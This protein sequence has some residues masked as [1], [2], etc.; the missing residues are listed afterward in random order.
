MSKDNSQPVRTVANTDPD[1]TEASELHKKLLEVNKKKNV[2]KQVKENPGKQPEFLN[3]IRNETNLLQPKVLLEAATMDKKLENATAGAFGTAMLEVVFGDDDRQIV[4]N[5]M[6]S[7]WRKITALRILASDGRSFAGTGWFISPTVLITA[8]HCVYMPK[9]GGWAQKIEVI[10]ALN[11]SKKPFGSTTATRFDTNEEWIRKGNTLYDY[12]AIFLEKAISDKIGSFDFGAAPDS[13]FS[14]FEVSISGYP[15]DRSDG[16]Q[17]YYH[18]RKVASAFPQQI[19]YEIDTFGGQSGGPIWIS[20]D[21]NTRIA[22]GIH[23][24][25]NISSNWGTRITPELFQNFKHWKE[26]G[27]GKK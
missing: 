14:D 7:P 2:I 22:I 4:T 15:T 18:T 8:G 20:P 13:Y 12:G 26:K 19:F 21:N 1:D 11:G 5:I 27:Y 16:S 24:N 9:A 6:E 10:P 23:T 25:G 17:Q 3:V